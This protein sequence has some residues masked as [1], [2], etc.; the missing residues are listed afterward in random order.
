METLR[1]S[2]INIPGVSFLRDARHF[3]ILFLSLFL[4]YGVNSLGWENEITRFYVTIG[5]ALATQALFN[6][7]YKL[8]L[9]LKSALISSF[10]LCLLLKTDELW[11]SALAAVIAI[12]SKFLI[13]L[14]GKHVFNPANIGIVASIFL[15]RQAY[16]S[17]GQWGNDIVTYSAVAILALV[18]LMK[19]NRLDT[20]FVF[21]GALMFL[22]VSYK[23]IY[24]GWDFQYFIHQF[25]NGTLMLFTFFMITDPM[26]T[27]NHVKGRVFWSICVALITFILIN[28]FYVYAEAPIYALFIMTLFTRQFD[29]WFKADK[30]K[31]QA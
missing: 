15:T 29:K 1:N 7:V 10:S 27:P 9:G 6:K 11:V 31:W 28:V 26:T 17:P 20:A 21:L 8:K 18:M 23:L 5:T 30:V 12:S 3:Q 22:E 25:T 4:L 16:V 24:M 14:K 13:R 19:V 2:I